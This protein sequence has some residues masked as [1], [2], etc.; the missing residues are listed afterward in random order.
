MKRLTKKQI[1]KDLERS[2]KIREENKKNEDFCL[3]NIF[4]KMAEQMK[5]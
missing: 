3:K 4:L 5:I 2:K 1:R